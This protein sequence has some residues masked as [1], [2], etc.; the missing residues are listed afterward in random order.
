MSHRHLDY[1]ADTLLAARG[2]SALDDLLDRGDLND[3]QPLVEAIA[4]DPFGD[5]AARVLHLCDVNPHYG[6]SPLWRAWIGRRRAM[7]EGGGAPEVSLAGLRRRLG[8]S[9]RELAERIGM[10]QSDL[11]KAERR[12]DWKLS[13]IVSII[14]G[15]GLRATVLVERAD[16]GAIARLRGSGSVNHRENGR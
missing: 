9:Q 12:S 14:E 8:L 3:W 13:T 1:P 10:S 11:S 5:V 15:L 2:D 6:T 4:A 16:G 7:A